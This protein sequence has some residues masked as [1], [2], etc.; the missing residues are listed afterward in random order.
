MSAPH[1]LSAI[2]SAISKEAVEAELCRRSFH[3]FFLRAWPT[4]EPGVPLREGLHIGVL[5]NA[6]QSVAEGRCKRLIINVPPRHTKSRIAS[7]AFP[8]WLWL[9]SPTAKILT[10]SHSDELALELGEE[11]RKLVESDWFRARW[12]ACTLV[13]GNNRKRSFKNVSGGSRRS[14]SAGGKATGFGGDFL[15]GDDVQDAQS[16]KSPEYLEQTLTWWRNTFCRRLNNAETG[17]IVLV[18]QRL[19]VGDLTARLT[20][21]G[22]WSHLC[23]PAAYDPGMAPKGDAPD[24]LRDPRKTPGQPL[25]GTP[26]TLAALK[27]EVADRWVW[28]AQYQQQP[29]PAG[30]VIL[31]SRHYKLIKRS[32]LPKFFAHYVA[33]DTAATEASSGDPT[34]ATVWGLSREPGKEGVFKLGQLEEWLSVP[35]LFKRIPEFAAKQPAGTTHL[36]ECAGPS[37]LAAYQHLRQSTKLPLVPINPKELGGGKE[38]RAKLAA[39][40]LE[41]GLI[42]LIEGEPTNESFMNQTDAFP[43]CR[44]RD[45]VDSAV[46]A[47]RYLFTRYTFESST[48]SPNR[49]KYVGGGAASKRK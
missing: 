12:P 34:A 24:W 13:H 21:I 43:R 23:L 16:A 9:R 48:A 2:A 8:V 10:A 25:W 49:F 18:M 36:I 35:S 32:E 41:A 20:E 17:A 31:E 39:A 30:G 38:D 15:I 19:E 22:G 4:M 33:W 26:L 45:L 1:P 14:V 40:H 28:A 7:V 37:G 3:E 6:L 47:W 11:S 27:A 29:I 44:P 42:W 5:C 46:Q